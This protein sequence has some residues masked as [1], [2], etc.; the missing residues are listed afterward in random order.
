MQRPHGT[1]SARDVFD[2]GCNNIDLK[3]YLFLPRRGG[4]LPVLSA[5]VQRILPAAQIGTIV[6]TEHDLPLI[7]FSGGSFAEIRREC[8]IRSHIPRH[9]ARDVSSPS[10]DSPICRSSGAATSPRPART[11]SCIHGN[12]LDYLANASFEIHEAITF[13]RGLKNING[14]TADRSREG[15]RDGPFLRR[16]RRVVLRRLRQHA[17]AQDA[18]QCTEPRLIAKAKALIAPASQSWD[19]F[20]NDDGVLDDELADRSRG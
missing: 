1:R 14:R 20:D 10:R 7:V 5:R 3:G 13:M 6:T 9:A 18:C 8:W 19:G 12:S 16:H 17:A 11:S 4:A 2:S 15:C